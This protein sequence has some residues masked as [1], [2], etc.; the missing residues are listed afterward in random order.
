ML[1][2]WK[3]SKRELKTKTG[4]LTVGG[5]RPLKAEATAIAGQRVQGIELGR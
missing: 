2:S 1:P 5:A 3:A 4:V